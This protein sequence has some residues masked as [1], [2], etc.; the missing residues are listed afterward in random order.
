MR[1]RYSPVVAVLLI[2][3]MGLQSWAISN[4]PKSGDSSSTVFPS[5]FPQ[6]TSSNDFKTRKIER[7]SAVSVNDQIAAL[8]AKVDPSNIPIFEF[9]HDLMSILETLKEDSTSSSSDG[10]TIIGNSMLHH[11]IDPLL[12]IEIE[13]IFHRYIDLLK[14]FYIESFVNYESDIGD[15]IN[16]IHEHENLHFIELLKQKREYILEECKKAMTAA[17][18]IPISSTSSSLSIGGSSSIESI[19]P[20]GFLSWD[21]EVCLL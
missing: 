5:T 13:S 2:A 21:F 10:T 18:S 3:C 1:F 20:K 14:A 4:I 7:S 19:M 17:V 6:D 9:S 11:H 12:L 8:S 15:Q 16:V